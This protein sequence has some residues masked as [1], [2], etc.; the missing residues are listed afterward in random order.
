TFFFFY[1][2]RGRGCPMTLTAMGCYRDYRGMR[3][4]PNLIMNQRGIDGFWA[5]Y[6]SVLPSCATKAKEMGYKYIGIQYYGECWAGDYFARP[7]KEK[8]SCIDLKFRTCQKMGP[9]RICSGKEWTNFIYGLQEY[10][11][12]RIHT[13]VEKMTPE[14][15]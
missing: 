9:Y 1:L 11:T 12:Y 7:L 2:A 4:L 5:N 6:T 10:K 8:R 15:K 14:S 3:V 13:C